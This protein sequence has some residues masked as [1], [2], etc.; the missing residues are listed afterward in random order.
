MKSPTAW[1][2]VA[3]L[4]SQSI[5]GAV[6]VRIFDGLVNAMLASQDEE[7]AFL[8]TIEAKVD[9]LLNADAVAANA[10]LKHALLVGR[11]D[12]DKFEDIRRARDLFIRAIGQTASGLEAA[13]TRRNVA[14]CARVL[15]DSAV[16]AAELKA[17]KDDAGRWLSMLETR[18][19][20]PALNAIRRGRQAD[21][22]Y[23]GGKLALIPGVLVAI[24]APAAFLVGGVAYGYIVYKKGKAADRAWDDVR[25]QVEL[26]KAFQSHIDGLITST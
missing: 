24:A 19:A 4:F 14:V 9:R 2:R 11:S 23:Y 18:T 13:L 22:Y 7:L 6:S 21:R 25:D 20:E 26:T 5:G 17:A 8:R 16:V 15:M 1:E 12:G 3:L 10:H